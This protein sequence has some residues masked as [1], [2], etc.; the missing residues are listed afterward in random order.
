M[1][2]KS[3]LFALI[4]VILVIFIFLFFILKPE[5]EVIM[6]NLIGQDISEVEKFA[7]KYN[8]D[9]KID[10]QYSKTEKENIVL[11]QSIKKGSSLKKFKKLRVIV[12]KGSI[13]P[14]EYARSKVNELGN[15]PVMMYHG[16]HNKSNSETN[17]IGGNVDKDGYQRTSEAFRN[18]LET[19]YQQ[20]YRMIRLDDYVEG[21]IDV[22]FGKSPIVLTFDDGLDNNIK[23]T[24]LD[25]NGNIIIDPNS[26]VGI[27]EEFKAKYPDYHVTATFFVNSSLFNQPEYDDK[28]LL[29]LLDNGYDIGNH[30]MTHP[31]FTKIDSMK[32][33]LE[34]GKLYQILDDKISNRYVNIVALPFGSPYSKGHSNFN[35]IIKGSIDGYNYETK[36]TL[37]VG[38]EA[39]YS[40]FDINFDPL[41]IKRIRA[42]DNNGQDFDIE[43]NLKL[44]SNKKYISDGDV[45]TIVVPKDIKGNLNN[46]KN[47]EVITY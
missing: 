36:A 11:E 3:F 16:I 26:A 25:E 7:K 4:M 27:L 44:L 1:R 6:P 46:T 17:Y 33:Q 43:M 34:I 31:D 40:P 23:V 42:Y 24:G 8:L 2:R 37:R 5:K 14:E 29:W 35:Y 22:E 32:T 10:R 39:D 13:K 20:G 47:L 19:Y 41:L 21:K 9:L 28:I 18:D 38:W 15:I 30:S 45:D 12:S